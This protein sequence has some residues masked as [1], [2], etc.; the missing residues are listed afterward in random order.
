MRSRMTALRAKTVAATLCYVR[1]GGRTLMLH[2][3]K[4]EGDVHLGKWNG[5]GGK[6]DPRESPDDC[7]VRE[8]HEESGLTVSD[9]RL[10]TGLAF[11]G[12]AM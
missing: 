8:V 4:K 6:M 5:L 2:R 1:S 3:N 9:A 12:I 10:R 11:H 7:V